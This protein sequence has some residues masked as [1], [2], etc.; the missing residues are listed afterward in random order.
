MGVEGGGGSKRIQ[1]YSFAVQRAF[2]ELETRMNE[3]IIIKNEIIKYSVSCILH[4]L[5]PN[6]DT[7]GWMD[8]TD[9]RTDG[10]T[11]THTD[12]FPNSDMDYRICNVRT[13][14]HD[15]SYASV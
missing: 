12:A 15:H 8:G 6:T 1:P 9:G 7:D 5:L 13:C 4:L 14:I 3:I 2:G 10:R 11:H